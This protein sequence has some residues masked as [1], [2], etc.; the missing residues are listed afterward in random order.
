MRF[1]TGARHPDR[2]AA[3]RWLELSLTAAVV[4]ATSVAGRA[5]FVARGVDAAD[6]A[7]VGVIIA[8]LMLW[9]LPSV[10]LR[11][12]SRLAVVLAGSAVAR[13][14]TL[15]SVGAGGIASVLVWTVAAVVTLVL[16]D[17]LGT[18][19]VPEAPATE[20]SA[21]PVA[22][23]RRRQ[24]ARTFGAAAIVAA[25]AVL[26]VI[27][28][29]PFAVSRFTGATEAGRGPTSSGTT[30]PSLRRSDQMDMTRNPALTDDVLLTVEAD[31]ATYLRGEVFDVWNGQQWR[32]SDQNRYAVGADGRP[33]LD[34]DDLGASGPVTFVQRVRVEASTADLYLGA[35][36]V[37]RLQTQSSISQT[38]DGSLSTWQQPLGAGA[39]YTVTSRGFALT[40]DLLQSAGDA[41]PAR[42][43][44]QYAASPVTTE[45][46][47][48]LAAQIVADAGASTTY[49]KIEALER[50]MGKNLEYS[51]DAPPSALG[52]DAVD[53][54]LFDTKLGWCQQI[55]SS[56]VVMARSLGL[57]ARVATGFVATERDP[58]TGNLV[59]RGR[60]AHAWA[61]VWFPRY[62]WVPFDPTAS[63]PLAPQV[64][65]H[66]TWSDW[67]RDHVVWVLGAAGAVVAMGMAV[68]WFARRLRRARSERPTSAAARLDRDLVR[69]GERWGVERA[70]EDTA[71]RLAT[72]IAGRADRPDLVP[73]GELIDRHLYAVAPPPETEL[74]AATAVVDDVRASAPRRRGGRG[75]S[76]NDDG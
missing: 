76:P 65:R 41:V 29:V 22:P 1:G 56:L 19:A 31:H 18:E 60:D 38:F 44:E 50:W 64:D 28:A 61:E 46:V 11:V 36:A 53:Q 45:R 32:R 42:V 6:G 24:Q 70:P 10:S 26:V 12:A 63:V 15:S 57:P 40:E 34:P 3:P 69:A 43:L 5:M 25:V 51:I 13:F 30:S 73:V 4:A 74:V 7:A 54:F 52:T 47:R 8:M 75:R 71:T 58:L 2:I 37:V 49:A 20:P 67:I 27:V 35:P 33:Q 72:R 21:A 66:D 68:R 55:A 62:G 48:A 9:G 17:R 23:Q 16:S 39:T 14:A 59:V